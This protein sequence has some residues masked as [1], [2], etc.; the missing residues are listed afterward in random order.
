MMVASRNKYIWI[1]LDNSPHVPLFKPIID[2]LKKRDYAIMVTARDCFQVCALADL[3]NIEY[4]KVGY[5]HGKNKILKVAGLFLRAMQLLPSIISKRPSLTLSHGSRS[6]LILSKLLGI[7][8][9][10]MDDYEPSKGLPFLGP[11]WIIMPEVIPDSTSKHP[12]EFV[13]R[14]PG[15]KE[16]VYVPFF[17][18]DPSILKDLNVEQDDL[19]VVIRPP[20]TEAHYHN[21]ESEVLFKGVVDFLRNKEGVR[22]VL[23]PRTEKQGRAA[24]E[25][26]PDVFADGKIMIPPRVVN[27]LNLIWHADLVIS[28]GGTMNREASA[29]GVPVYSIFRGT[30]GA[31]DKYLAKAGRLILLTSLEDVKQKLVLV[32]R[33]RSEGL[34]PRNNATLISI[35][36]SIEFILHHISY[37]DSKKA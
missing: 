18:P 28:G 22:M 29:L 5:H 21:P 35:I 17:K 7:P 23:L 31:V 34:K 10:L 13:R 3:H 8:S 24:R 27:G 2:E 19:L 4:K 26:W 33:E 20:A 30:I 37:R 36:D 14:Y 16:D 1:D 12:R 11:D 15:I 6:Q 9:V 25:T 32:R